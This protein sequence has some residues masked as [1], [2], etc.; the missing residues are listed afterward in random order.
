M[1]ML[2][3]LLKQ[4]RKWHKNR[5]KNSSEREKERN[6]PFRSWLLWRARAAREPKSWKHFNE[7]A[8]N[9]EVWSTYCKIHQTLAWIQVKYDI[10]LHIQSSLFQSKP[11]WSQKR[12]RRFQLNL[13]IS[14]SFRADPPPSTDQ[15]IPLPINTTKNHIAF[16]LFLRGEIYKYSAP[17]TPVMQRFYETAREAN[18]MVIAARPAPRG[19]GD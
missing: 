15:R 19:N 7:T 18:R 2:L 11:L 5:N 9:T 13:S 3:L 16:L 10:N 12:R 17:M 1:K 6:P 8:I 4:K 14:G